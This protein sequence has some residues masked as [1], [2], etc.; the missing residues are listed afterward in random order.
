MFIFY[1]QAEFGDISHEFWPKELS[2]LF[3][4]IPSEPEVCNTSFG[5]F[6]LLFVV[7]VCFWRGGGVK[8]EGLL[9]FYYYYCFAFF[10]G[11]NM[12]LWFV[13]VELCWAVE[14]C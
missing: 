11:W 10:G 2:S 7:F 9:L 1:F 4:A 3:D 14:F 13:F 12:F 5:V 6:C 8:G